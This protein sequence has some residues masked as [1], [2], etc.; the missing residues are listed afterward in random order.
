MSILLLL[1][2]MRVTISR[3]ITSI[4]KPTT[5]R[6]PNSEPTTMASICLVEGSMPMASNTASGVSMPTA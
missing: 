2:K 1:R 5:Q 3:R 6:M 4:S